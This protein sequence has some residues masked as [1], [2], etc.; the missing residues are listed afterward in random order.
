MR[1]QTT[2]RVPRNLW[3][4]PWAYMHHPQELA[5][6]QRDFPDDFGYPKFTPPAVA[7]VRGDRYAE[8]T[9]IDE[10][11]CEFFNVCA[12]IVGEVKRPMVEEYESDLGKLRPP[13]EHYRTDLS[14]V[15]R[16][17]AESDK[18][19]IVNP[20][21]NP[22]ERMQFL[23]GTENLFC[24]LM[25]QPAGLFKLRDTV[26]EWNM[27]MISRWCATDVDA[28]AWAD[29]WGMQ[30]RLLIAPDL[31]RELFKP[32]YRDYA[33]LIHK[34]GKFTMMHSDGNIS[35]IYE[36]LIEVGVDAINSQLF[37]MNIE[38]LGRRY[39]GRITFWGEIDR[40]H[41]LPWGTQTDTRNAVRRCAKALYDGNG[42]VIAQCEFSAGSKPENVRVV[43]EEWDAV[44][45]G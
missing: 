38:D 22:F 31:W 40:Q 20:G 43:F 41:T 10:W 5:A 26:H 16:Q 17:C 44:C 14:D 35:A 18:F 36:D 19:V 29:D 23:R 42:G 7:C 33:A 25:E 4:L 2:P 30:D 45:A 9:F 13:V 28:I 21:L 37:C 12:G 34:A 8:G 6:I 39:K 1:F 24:D 11:G 15:N 3:T 32:L 27:E